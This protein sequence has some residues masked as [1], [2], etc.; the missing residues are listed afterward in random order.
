MRIIIHKDFNKLRIFAFIYWGMIIS[1]GGMYTMYISQIGFHKEEMGITVTLYSVSMLVGHSFLGY[2]VDKLRCIKKIMLSSIS[3]GLI[4]AAGLP[5]ARLNWQVCLLI[6]MWG[7]FIG[8]ASTL[9][10][11]WCISTLKAYGEQNNFGKIRGFGSVGYGLSGALLG[12]LLSKFGWNIYYLY[13]AAVVMFTLIII[14]INDDRHIENMRDK[15]P[16]V[17]IK[18]ALTQIL[19]I[20]PFIIMLIIVFTYNFIY[21]G[22]YNYLGV[23]VK[24]YGGG[25]LSL[26]LTY[27][28]DAAPEIVTYFLTASLLKKY[29]NKSLIFVAFLLQAIRLVVIY[30]FSNALAVMLMGILSGF[31]FGLMDASYKTYIYDLAPEKYKT[32]C[33]SL[34]D[35]IVGFSGIICAPIFGF[36]FVRLG[37]N[38]IIV[39]A[40]IIDIIMASVMLINMLYPV[41]SRKGFSKCK[42]TIKSENTNNVR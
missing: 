10:D 35:C 13:I 25:A 1:V 16:N 26:G 7:F 18:E 14:Y 19:K 4:I 30:I 37:T 38:A 2:L 34:F 33:L 8:G 22:I 6:A 28:F 39:F 12:L 5:L 9:F 24:D 29:K 11:T 27:F 17:S 20:K 3:I 40:L 42:T 41:M 36:L 23:L 31:A 15:S 32:S 21:M